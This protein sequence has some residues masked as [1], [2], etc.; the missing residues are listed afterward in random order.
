MITSADAETCWSFKVR[1]NLNLSSSLLLVWG[2]RMDQETGLE[3]GTELWPARSRPLLLPLGVTASSPP[4]LT[5]NVQGRQLCYPSDL[6]V[7]VERC[8]WPPR[9]SVTFHEVLLMVSAD[10]VTCVWG[11]VCFSWAGI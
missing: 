3:V 1:F 10:V 11:C 8:P 6:L 2:G 4:P 5:S 7:V 9:G